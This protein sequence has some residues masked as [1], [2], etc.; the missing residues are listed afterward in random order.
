MRLR[1]A[2]LAF[3]ALAQS[4]CSGIGYYT[5][6]IHGQLSLL[7]KR[8]PIAALSESH[9]LSE[10]LRGTL[11][12]V[13][14]IRSFASQELHLPDNASYRSYAD[15]GRP[16]VVWN[17]FA[18]PELS[19]EP[20][21]WCF[22]IVGC[23]S[24]RGYFSETRAQAYA[25]RLQAAG[26]D[27]YIGGV[28]AFS[29]LGWFADPVLSTMVSQSPTALAAV[30]FHELAH[31]RLYLKGDTGFNEAFAVTV[32]REG[33]ERWLRARGW[34]RE[35][36]VYR[37]EVAQRHRFLDWVDAT[38]R[39]LSALYQQPIGANAKRQRK[40]LILSSLQDSQRRGEAIGEIGDY[41]RWF[42]SGLNNAKLASVATYYDLVPAFQR[43]LAFQD[44]DLAAFY[45]A[46]ELLAGLDTDER[47]LLLSELSADRS[48]RQVARDP[49]RQEHRVRP[50]TKLSS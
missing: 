4:G 48:P 12:T 16:Y 37:R 8:K 25:E 26:F 40:A 9:S 49:L 28:R 46:S 11:R 3:G 43:L 21:V 20:K 7:G 27:T 17:V 30:I 29:T 15:V 10:Q 13:L 50:V 18:T 36:Q 39:Q 45:R 34:L 24:Y 19:L 14:D 23:V 6:S 38:R 1:L 5:Q 32:E 41:R 22:P 33:V 2:L 44:N 47:R 42:E 31:Q 35:L